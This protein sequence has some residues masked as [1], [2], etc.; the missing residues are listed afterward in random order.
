[1]RLLR[2]DFNRPLAA[3]KAHQSIPPLGAARKQASTSVIVP[4]GAGRNNEQ[5]FFITEPDCAIIRQIP[6]FRPLENTILLQ[7]NI[8]SLIVTSGSLFHEI[9][10][11]KRH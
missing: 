1:L 2:I 9:E 4:L 8:G 3:A 5:H 6:Q 10:R 11:P 7:V